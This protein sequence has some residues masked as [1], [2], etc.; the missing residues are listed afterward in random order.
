MIKVLA[1]DLRLYIQIGNHSVPGNLNFNIPF[2]CSRK[3]KLKK[4]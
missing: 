2:A 3:I 4:L 1:L